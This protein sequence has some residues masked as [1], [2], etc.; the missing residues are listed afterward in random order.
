MRHS[1]PLVELHVANACNLTCDS[2]SHFS[3]SGHRGMLS[4]EEARAWL[5]PWSR[6]LAPENFR[7]LGGEPTLNPRLVEFVKIGRDAFPD[8]RLEVVTNGFFLHRQ[9]E[10]PRALAEAR[11]TVELTIHH[12]SPEYLAQLEPVH[13]LLAEWRQTYGVE[14]TIEVADL[15]WTRR[16]H[17]FGPDVR[18]Y[19]DR[20]LRA[21]WEQCPASDCRQL[22]RGRLWKCSPITYLRLQKEAF[23]EISSEWDPYLAYQGIE[24]GC[25][26][27]ELHAFLA[28]QEEPICGMCPADPEQ[29][30]KESP[31]IPRAA[32]L[33]AVRA[34]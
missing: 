3:N 27:E 11:A 26:D 17:G 21:S 22:F 7:L 33:K 8:T 20:N 13:A 34:R 15:R 4:P 32:L 6:R 9:P 2:C 19:D 30:E 14:H 10:L 23:S 25:T 16:Y 18:P 31:L 1:L 12:R 5:A 28:R 29:F 24:P